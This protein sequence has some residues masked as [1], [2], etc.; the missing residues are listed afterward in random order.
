M[1]KTKIKNLTDL[2]KSSAAEYGEK[3]FIKELKGKTLSE[4]SFNKFYDGVKK[5]SGYLSGKYDDNVHAAVIGASSSEWLTAWFGVVCM[6]GAAVPLDANLPCEEIIDLLNRSDSSVF[7]YDKKYEKM[8]PEIKEKCP[9]V[10]EYVSLYER[11]PEIISESE[12]MEP[13]DVSPDSLAAISY[14]SGTTGKSKGVMLLHRNFIDNTMCQDDEAT[15]EDVIMSVLPIHHIYCFT[16]DILCS[17]RYGT[18]LC[19]NDSMLHIGQNLKLFR[20][21]MVLF[22][23]M[24]AETIYKQIKSAAAANPALTEKQIAA[25][26]FGGRLTTVYSGGAY[27]RPEL[28]KAYID[29]G[30]HMAQGY[31]MTECSPRISTADKYD[32]ECAGDVG[33]IVNGAE[34][35]TEDGELMVKSQSVMAGY[36]KDEEETKKALTP[37]GWLRTG[38]LGYVDEKNRI[39]ITGR[40]KNLII[41]SNGENVSPE[42]LENKYAGAEFISEILVYSE[43][44]VITAEIFPSAEYLKT[45]STEDVES[46]FRTL[47]EKINKNVISSKSIHR[48]RV[49]D[50]EFEKTSS[51]KIKRDGQSKGRI[52]K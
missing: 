22:V 16:C 46:E 35:K 51:K 50:V 20:P 3:T 25:G 11:L 23:P 34:V 26:V 38:D 5:L 30:F 2:I 9:E 29:M 43:D 44:G 49:R 28:Q 39:F 6:G 21:T 48:L 1:D 33:I 36:Y 24:I 4:I 27:L 18:E 45:H 47:T 41:L 12:P 13:K 19:L 8:I 7:F 14:T 17:L 42:E 37:D 40:K 31:G 52:L 10:K 15:T 32:T